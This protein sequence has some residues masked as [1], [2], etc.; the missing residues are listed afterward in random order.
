MELTVALARAQ[1]ILCSPHCSSH[2]CR[3]P[4]ALQLYR[5][6]LRLADYISTQV[7]CCLHQ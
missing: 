1:R 3:L 7:G 4:H 5:D 6:C 2:P